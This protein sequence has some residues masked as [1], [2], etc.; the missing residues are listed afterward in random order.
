MESTPRSCR[1]SDQL[2][3]GL[4]DSD[5]LVIAT[6]MRNFGIPSA[7]KA[8]IGPVVRLGRASR[9]CDSGVL[10]LAKGKQAVLSLPK[11]AHALGLGIFT[12]PQ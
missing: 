1:R 3:G 2:T 6:P 7:L 4:L 8:W 5:L 9:H 12:S 11:R 10:A